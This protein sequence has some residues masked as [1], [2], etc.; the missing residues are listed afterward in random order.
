MDFQSAEWLE[1]CISNSAYL[2]KMKNKIPIILAIGIFHICTLLIFLQRMFHL[3]F[4]KRIGVLLKDTQAGAGAEVD[5]LAAIICAWKFGWVF[6]LPAAGSFVFGFN[7]MIR[8]NI[9]QDHLS[10]GL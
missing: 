2:P 3:P 7:G 10:F 1:A 4:H 9:V 5:P 6:D 8:L